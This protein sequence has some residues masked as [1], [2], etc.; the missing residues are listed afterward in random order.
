MGSPTSVS[1]DRI[2]ECTDDN[3]IFV[4]QANIIPQL[5][6]PLLSSVSPSES[7]P[8]ESTPPESTPPES[9]PPE[10]APPEST[11]PES[12]PS[13]ST[14]GDIIRMA[15]ESVEQIQTNTFVSESEPSNIPPGESIMNEL[16]EN[17]YLRE[18]LN[19]D[20]DYGDFVGIDAVEDEGIELNHFDEIMDDIEPFDFDLF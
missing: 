12:T 6:I 9:T 16:M 7:T 18:L 20:V 5:R 3:P 11:P 4:P 10:S 1:C 2:K 17:E 13:E 15:F 8:S 19:R 14:G